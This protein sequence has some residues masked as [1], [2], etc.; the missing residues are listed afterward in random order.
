MKMFEVHLIFRTKYLLPLF[1]M[2]Q[3]RKL[4]A[5]GSVYCSRTLSSRI[6]VIF[7]EAVNL[8][9]MCPSSLHL[10]ASKYLFKKYI[11]R[12]HVRQYFGDGVLLLVN[13]LEQLP[14][15]F[16]VFHTFLL[17]LFKNSFLLV[18]WGHVS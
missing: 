13:K 10:P 6:V 8:Q 16:I 1:S 5:R 2:A 17:Y 15:E 14:S 9:A 7:L 12:G 4:R 11:G 18:A 3:M